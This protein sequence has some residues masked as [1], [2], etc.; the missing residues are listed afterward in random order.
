[1]RVVVKMM[2]RSRLKGK[3]ATT[4]GMVG[5]EHLIPLSEGEEE[6]EEEEEVGVEEV[7]VAGGVRMR[8][9]EEGK[10]QGSKGE[11]D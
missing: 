10:G 6:E 1:M 11:R 2:G 8:I 3:M 7:E 5:R 4:N 9:L